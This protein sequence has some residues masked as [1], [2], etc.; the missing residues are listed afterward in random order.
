MTYSNTIPAN[1]VVYARTGAQ[2]EL[3]DAVAKVQETHQ[4]VGVL[5]SRENDDAQ[6]RAGSHRALLDL[7]GDGEHAVEL[8]ADNDLWA[9]RRALERFERD[10]QDNARALR[11]IEAFRLDTGLTFKSA[12]G[13]DL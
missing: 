2:A 10:H 6:A 12:E 7:L 4:R 11:E 13:G 9:L 5:Q 3:Q 1:I 8:P